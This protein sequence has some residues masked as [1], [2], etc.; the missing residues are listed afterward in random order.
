MAEKVKPTAQVEPFHDVLG[1]DGTIDLLL[2]FSGTVLY[3]PKSPRNSTLARRFG[4]ERVAALAER[5]GEMYV[6]VPSQNR[7]LAA[8]L[9]QRG[10]SKADIA[11]KLRISDVTVRKY[12]RE[13]GLDRDKR[14]GE[15]F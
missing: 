8:I 5:L 4:V 6:R 9:F 7:W 2:E 12:L 11:R 3:L 10:L 13:A 15:L 14:Q 1:E